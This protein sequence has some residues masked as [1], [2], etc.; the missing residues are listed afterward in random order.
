MKPCPY[1]CNANA[2]PNACNTACIPDWKCTDWSTCANC[3][4]AN[5]CNN[6][7]YLLNRYS[8][9]RTC[10][11][12]NNCGTTTGKPKTVQECPGTPPQVQQQPQNTGG[13]PPGSSPNKKTCTPAYKCYNTKY[14]GYQDSNCKWSQLKY[15]S[16]GCSNNKCNSF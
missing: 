4:N 13:T 12:N 5:I 14:A 3:T 9:I 15:C 11:D 8:Q 16:K 6:L 10:T 7:G 1:G 2:N